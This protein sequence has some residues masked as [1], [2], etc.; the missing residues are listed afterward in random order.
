[1]K[2]MHITET[3]LRDA[4]QSLIATRMP[5]DDFEAVLDEMDKAGYHSIEC[6]GG[7]TFDD[8]L[9][10][11]NEDPWERLRKIK[12]HMKHTKLQMLLRGQNLL[13]Y[14]HY[15][16]DTV[17]RFVRKRV[18]NGMDSIRILDALNDLRNSETAEEECLE[19]GGQA[20]GCI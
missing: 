8:C 4:Q 17:R 6:W 9:R 15:S 14:H 19:D 10:Y 11:L 5:F 12:A 7:T 20:Q 18:E 1:M 3:V 16:D 2:Q 13:G